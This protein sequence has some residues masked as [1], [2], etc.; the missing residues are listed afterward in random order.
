MW[1]AG[2]AGPFA[3]REVELAIGLDKPIRVLHISDIHF[4]PGQKKKAGFL[5]ELAGTES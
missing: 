4:A 3:L 5:K 2:N 1:L